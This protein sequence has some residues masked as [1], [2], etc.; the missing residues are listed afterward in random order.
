MSSLPPRKRSLYSNAWKSSHFVKLTNISWQQEGNRENQDNGGSR[1]TRRSRS[2]R[3]LCWWRGQQWTQLWPSTVPKISTCCFI[4]S[5]VN[6]VNVFSVDTAAYQIIKYELCSLF[7]NN[8]ENNK[9]R[10]LHYFCMNR[11]NTISISLRKYLQ[12]GEMKMAAA[13]GQAWNLC[14]EPLHTLRYACGACIL[15][16][17]VPAVLLEKQSVHVGKAAS[18]ELHLDRHPPFSLSCSSTLSSSV[19]SEVS[20]GRCGWHWYWRKMGERGD[21]PKIK[22]G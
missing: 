11:I 7:K 3:L 16:V 4:D 8:S 1:A 10:D 19:W 2:Q 12:C 6:T 20:L 17:C 14:W 13:Q 18:C 15:L 22:L 21:Q 5:S 9:H